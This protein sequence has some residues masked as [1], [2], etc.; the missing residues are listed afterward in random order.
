[1]YERRREGTLPPRLIYTRTGRSWIG[2]ASPSLQREQFPY[3]IQSPQAMVFYTFYDV[4]LVKP[5]RV[6]HCCRT[7][8][9]DWHRSLLKIC[10]VCKDVP[11]GEQKNFSALDNRLDS[12][13]NLLRLVIVG[14]SY[15]SCAMWPR[16]ELRRGSIS[17]ST[18]RGLETKK[19]SDAQHSAL[20]YSQAVIP[21]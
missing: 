6:T 1:V 7:I 14:F 15:V 8:I 11:Q 4:S 17:V 13:T 21:A 3:S 19:S 20:D 10:L 5:G 18:G 9:I 12:P 16:L 2:T